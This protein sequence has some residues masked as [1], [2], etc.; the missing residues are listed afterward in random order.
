MRPMRS[1]RK[2]RGE[3]RLWVKAGGSRAQQ[4][5]PLRTTRQRVRKMSAR[6]FVSCINQYA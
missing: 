2:K 3:R 5:A 6:R 1:P 4:A